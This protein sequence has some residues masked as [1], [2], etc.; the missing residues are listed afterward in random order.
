MR[1][2]KE[3]LLPGAWAPVL[4]GQT[5]LIWVSWAW[6]QRYRSK[7]QRVVLLICRPLLPPWGLTLSGSS[8]LTQGDGGTNMYL[9]VQVSTV[10][11][12]LGLS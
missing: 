5:R 3:G 8:T 4:L 12:S 9:G 7:D 10:T 1:A 11:F 2:E 6:G